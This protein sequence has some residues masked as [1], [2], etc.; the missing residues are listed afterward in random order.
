MN[1][2]LIPLDILFKNK[3]SNAINPR[4][5]LFLFS[6]TIGQSILPDTYDLKNN[7]QEL[8]DQKS[9]NSCVANSVCLA[10]RIVQKNKKFQPSRLYIYYKARQKDMGSDQISDSGTYIDAALKHIQQHGICSE[11]L[12]E[13]NIDLV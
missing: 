13:Y 8:Y 11:K 9:I 4:P 1:R 12:W 7:I 5:S 3:I 6:K 2:K 10:Y